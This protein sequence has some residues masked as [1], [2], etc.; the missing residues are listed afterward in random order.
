MELKNKQLY[1]EIIDL[2]AGNVEK[3]RTLL[4]LDDNSDCD[5]DTLTMQALARDLPERLSTVMYDKEEVEAVHKLVK[6]IAT[7]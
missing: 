7:S 6:R 3:F 1:V 5:D 4:E 2:V